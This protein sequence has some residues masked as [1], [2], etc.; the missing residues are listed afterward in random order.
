MEV[1]NYRLSL[2]RSSV[3]AYECLLFF[4]YYN[5]SYIPSLT[6]IVILSNEILQDQSQYI[7]FEFLHVLL[8]ILRSL[9]YRA[10]E[11]Y[12]SVELT[13]SSVLIVYIPFVK[14]IAKC[15][16]TIYKRCLN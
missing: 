14:E 10:S 2:T 13:P 16:N 4:D 8:L 7:P 11:T 1:C 15:C 3:L 12:S 9:Y 5:I 6:Q